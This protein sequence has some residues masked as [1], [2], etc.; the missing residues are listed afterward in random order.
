M[1]NRRASGPGSK[2]L[3]EHAQ[4]LLVNLE[5][6]DQLDALGLWA[7]EVVQPTSEE[8][9]Q[10]FNALSLDKQSELDFLDP[11]YIRRKLDDL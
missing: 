2:S 7:F 11:S 3:S 4:S 10:R 1:P 6:R 5:D 9:L 8:L